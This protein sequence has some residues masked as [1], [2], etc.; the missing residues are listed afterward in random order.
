MSA[1]IMR[2]KT[3]T[4]LAPSTESSLNGDVPRA[5]WLTPCLGKPSNNDHANVWL[6]AATPARHGGTSTA[7]AAGAWLEAPA[8]AGA[9]LEAAAAASAWLEAAAP[10]R[11][12]VGGGAAGAAAGEGGKAGGGG[13]A[14]GSR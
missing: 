6:E 9:W 3:R 5:A 13:G 2:P 1:C 10:T 11:H 4:I 8:A 7:A 12:G 14:A